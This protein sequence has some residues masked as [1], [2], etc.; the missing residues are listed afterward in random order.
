[1]YDGN[2]TRLSVFRP[3][4]ISPITFQTDLVFHKFR[5]KMIETKSRTKSDR[6]MK[7]TKGKIITI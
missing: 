1:M 5:N 7:I 3:K 6:V 2:N 4:I